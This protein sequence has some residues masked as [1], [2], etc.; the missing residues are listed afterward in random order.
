MV[1]ISADKRIAKIAER[2]TPHSLDT[3]SSDVP[4]AAILELK[5][6]EA[7]PSRPAQGRPRELDIRPVEPIPT[8]AA[9]I[10]TSSPTIDSR[11]SRGNGAHRGRT[12]QPHTP[13]SPREK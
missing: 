11:L 12:G 5:G 2:T 13:E 4:V 7:E 10:S 3:I 1:F 6:G 8:A 9:R